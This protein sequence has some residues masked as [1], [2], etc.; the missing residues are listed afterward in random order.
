MR[1][2][3]SFLPALLFLL[4]LPVWT[5]V[6][7]VQNPFREFRAPEQ[8]FS[9]EFPWPWVPKVTTLTQASVAEHIYEVEIGK[10]RVFQVRALEFAANNVPHSDAAYYSGLIQAFAGNTGSKVRTTYPYA[11]GGYAGMAGVLE[12]EQR[13][14]LEQLRVTYAVLVNVAQI[15]NRLYFVISAGPFGHELT[16]FAT[17]FRDSF[18]IINEEKADSGRAYFADAVLRMAPRAARAASAKAE[19]FLVWSPPPG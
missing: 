19:S 4:V 1:I 15:R 14:F 2:R 3:L 18:K 11:I 12:N 5:I 7:A 10:L 6:K 13:A 8:G 9:V 16:P 17:H